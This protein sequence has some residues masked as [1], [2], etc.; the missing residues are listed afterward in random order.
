MKRTK[1]VCTLG[2]ASSSR[3]TIAAMIDAGM[4]VAR[5]NFSHG[6]RG[7]HGRALEVVR[8]AATEAGRSVAVLQDLAGPKTRIGPVEA[9]Q[10]VLRAG[11]PFVLTAR[12]VPGDEHEVSLTYTDL[13]KDVS[14]GDRLLLADG[15]IELRAEEVSDSDI[16]TTVVVGGPLSSHKGIN[17]PDRTIGAPILS[18]KDREDLAFG[19]SI[20]V[21]YVALSFVRSADDVMEARRIIEDSGSPAG[22]IAKIEKHEAVLAIDE[23]IELVDGVMIARGD[24]GVEVP[25]ETVPTIQKRIIEKTNRAG[26]PVITATQMLTSMVTSPQ[27]TRAEVSDAANAIIDGSDAVMLSEETAV[28]LYPAAAVAVLSRVADAQERVFPYEHW[29]ALMAEGAEMSA[30][31]AVAH[32]ACRIAEEIGA[33][34]II[35]FTRSGS[36]TRLVAKYRPAQPILAMTPDRSTAGRLALVWG[37]VPLLT[38]PAGDADAMEREAMRLALERGHVGEGDVVVITAGLPFYVPGTTN[39]IKIATVGGAP[40]S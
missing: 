22:L 23:I 25:V 18:E 6:E 15:T 20:G 39:L 35:T 24:L 17:L 32:S 30:D 27:P 36:T 13:P 8:A 16:R 29:T 26:K 12:D 1:I 40:S 33:R 37:A 7:E 34:A 38:G 5:L 9:G 2:P 31:E 21:D 4:D 10:I 14:P 19:L 28:G 3:E 11:S